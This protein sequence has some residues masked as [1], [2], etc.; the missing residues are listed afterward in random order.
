MTA[1]LARPTTIGL[2]AGSL[3]EAVAVDV[4]R[5]PSRQGLSAQVAQAAAVMG[6]SQVVHLGPQEDLG[7]PILAAVAAECLA[8]RLVLEVRA[9]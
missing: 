3:T 5:A 7:R 2:A 4:P 1:V 9:S 6:Q 8:V